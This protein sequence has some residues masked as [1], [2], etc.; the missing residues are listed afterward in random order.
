MTDDE[1]EEYYQEYYHKMFIV[2][3]ILLLLSILIFISILYIILKIFKKIKF[4]N[5]I[6]IYMLG[7]LALGQLAKSLF[8]YLNVYICYNGM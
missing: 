4:S 3:S 6:I 8:F 5:P 7:F 2:D 1:L